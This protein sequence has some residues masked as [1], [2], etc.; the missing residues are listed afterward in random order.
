MNKFISVTV[1]ILIL[2]LGIGLIFMPKSDFSENENRMLQ[3]FPKLSFNDFASGEYMEDITLYISDHFPLRDGFVTLKTLFAEKVMGNKLVNGIYV[4]DN[5]MY[6]EDYKKP[7]NTQRLI[8][9]FNK[10]CKNMEGRQVDLMLVP[11]A[12]E[13]YDDKLPPFASPLSQLKTMD[14]IYSSVECNNIDSLYD[15]L[16]LEKEKGKKLFY[17]L[18]HHWTTEGA[19]A[20]YTTWCR[21]KGIEPQ[22][23]SAFDIKTV[24]EDF[25]GTIY[26]KLNDIT[27][28]GEE[29]KVYEQD[30]DLTVLYDGEERDSL[31]NYDYLDKK[32]KYSLFL[33]N[34]HSLVEITNN[35]TDSTRTLA[36]AK[37]SYANSMI[38]F[39]VA[40]YKKIYVFDTRSYKGAVSDFVKENNIDDVLILY[41][42]NT[43]DTDT[44]VNVIY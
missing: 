42:M 19:Y 37:D 26:S 3:E 34:I 38:P 16:I 9:T 32:D 22:P 31:Y 43:I 35:S 23:E 7:E 29:I 30:N 5:G 11:T 12:V 21:A 8:D 39:L 20:G 17:G 13:I 44:G 10:F 36:I 15:E 40:H 28:K 27:L 14:K 4:C 18:D 24:T 25:K 33:N 41:N 2:A 6:I 1:T